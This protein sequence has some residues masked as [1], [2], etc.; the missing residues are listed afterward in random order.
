[1]YAVLL[2][3]APLSA[4]AQMQVSNTSP[5]QN[6]VASPGTSISVTF[7]QT[8][9][10]SANSSWMRVYSQFGGEVTGN[11]TT[12]GST[13]SFD[14]DSL[15]S[16]G[17]QVTVVLNGVTASGGDTL[18]GY[19][20]SFYIQSGT[21]TSSPAFFRDVAN[22]YVN[23]SANNAL[24][25]DMNGDH[26]PDLIGT[27]SIRR[28]IYLIQNRE[29]DDHTTHFISQES[30][31][32]NTLG[33]ATGDFD[34]DGDLDFVTASHGDNRLSLY[35][36]DG[37]GSFSYSILFANMASAA[38]ILRAVDFDNDNDTD[39]LGMQDRKLILLEND[40]T[41]NFTLSTLFDGSDLIDYSLGDLDGNGGVDVLASLYSLS[42]YFIALHNDGM[43][44]ISVDTIDVGAIAN[45]GALADI[46]KDGVPEIISY[47]SYGNL[48]GY[49]L[50]D[51]GY[52]EIPIADN[53][54]GSYKRM[55][56]GDLDGDG[57]VDLL[58]L[59][60]GRMVWFENDGTG[61]F[62]MAIIDQNL[63][64]S[65]QMGIVDW[66]GDGNVDLYTVDS[67]TGNYRWYRQT[68]PLQQNISLRY[69][70]SP[71]MNNETISLKAVAGDTIRINMAGGNTGESELVID[72]TVASSNLT[73]LQDLD[74]SYIHDIAPTDI[75]FELVV[76]AAGNQQE[77]Y[78]VYSNDPDDQVYTTYFS[79]EVFDPL[80]VTSSS[81][82]VMEANVALDAPISLGFS[83]VLPANWADYRLQV[84]GSQ[85]GLI[86][87]A[88]T[89]DN[90]STLSFVAD[91]NYHPAEKISVL[92]P[93]GITSPNGPVLVNSWH[94]TFYASNAPT[95]DSPVFFRDTL[96]A[97]I[98]SNSARVEVIDLDANG[99]PELLIGGLT[100]NRDVGRIVKSDSGYVS[101][102]IDNST[103]DTYSYDR[104]SG[105]G[106]FM[107]NEETALITGSRYLR[108][109]S[110][111][112]GENF[113]TEYLTYQSPHYIDGI[114]VGDIDNDGM[115][116]IISFSSGS[117]DNVFIYFSKSGFSF[118]S[119]NYSES[120][121]M[122]DLELF[123]YDLDGDL[124]IVTSNSSSIAYWTNQGNANFSIEYV[125]YSEFGT[126]YLEVADV[127]MD[128]YPDVVVSERYGDITWI[129]NDGGTF[130]TTEQTLATGANGVV[131][132]IADHDQDGDLD[133]FYFADNTIYLLEQEAI[134][135][136]S[137]R[138][139]Y[140][141]SGFVI[142][143]ALAD[144]DQ[145]GDLDIYFV[146]QKQLILLRNVVPDPGVLQV[147]NGLGTTLASESTLD[148][149]TLSPQQVRNFALYLDNTGEKDLTITSV[150]A[151]GALSITDTIGTIQNGFTQELGLSFTDSLTGL[152]SGTLSIHYAGGTDS[153]YTLTISAEIVNPLAAT[154]SGPVNNSSNVAAN[155]TASVVFS[156]VMPFGESH[157]D[158]V[159]LSG[160]ISG[161][162]PF[163]V[164]VQD[165]L[166]SFIP[167]QAFL[168]G[169][170]VRLL[171]PAGLRA[172]DSTALV[173]NQQFSYFIASAAPDTSDVTFI[174]YNRF[175][176]SYMTGL[177][178]VDANGDQKTDI[179]SNPSSLLRL[180]GQTEDYGFT[181]EDLNPAYRS[182]VIR[183]L[184]ADLDGDLDFLTLNTDL[185][186]HLADSGAYTTVVLVE[187]MYNNQ[188]DIIVAHL[189]DDLLPDIAAIDG[190]Q[191]F[192]LINN[193][194]GQFRKETL[195]DD[196]SALS[197]I[198]VADMNGDGYMDIAVGD[199]NTGNHY[200]CFNDGFG[201]FTRAQI[202]LGS[203][204]NPQQ[205]VLRDFDGDGKNDLLSLRLWSLQLWTQVDSVSFVSETILS[206]LSGTHTIDVG[207]IDGDG[208]QDFVCHSANVSD[209][210]WLENVDTTYTRHD[211]NLDLA[212]GFGQ[213]KNT[214]RLGDFDDDG[215][216]DLA[217]IGE[218][219][220]QDMLLV[221]GNYSPDPLGTVLTYDG[222]EL[223]SGDTVDL[224][225]FTQGDLST[226]PLLLKNTG[227][228][229]LSIDSLSAESPLTVADS[230][231]SLAGKETVSLGLTLPVDF[232]GAIES[233]VYLSTN[234]TTAGTYAIVFTGTVSSIAIPQVT[235]DSTVY[236]STSYVDYGTVNNGTIL[237]FTLAN[238][239]SDTLSIT[240]FTLESPL[241]LLDEAPASVAPGEEVSLQ[242][243]VSASYS[244]Y[245]FPSISFGHNGVDSLFL[246]E[247]FRVYVP[248]T[249]TVTVSFD[250][251]L[252]APGDTLQFPVTAQD[253]PVSK[254]MTLTNT[255]FGNLTVSDILYPYDMYVN[256]GSS[257]VLGE[258]ESTEIS[259]TY[260][261][262]DFGTNN[263]YI[264]I[265][266]N[267]SENPS[268][269]VN[270]VTQVDSVPEL[271]IRD[272]FD[273]VASG[274]SLVFGIIEPGD[275][276]GQV[277]TVRN[278]GSGALSL[279]SL[280]LPQG[281]SSSLTLPIELAPDEELDFSINFVPVTEG[282]FDGTAILYNNDSDEG[283]FEWQL[284]G[285][286]V[287]QPVM[288]LIAFGD[289][290]GSGQATPLVIAAPYTYP[291]VNIPLSNSGFGDLVI[292]NITV[293]GGWLF[294]GVL[295]IVVAPGE[296]TVLSIIAPYTGTT[297]RLKT[298]T[299]VLS[300]NQAGAESFELVA[301]AFYTQTEYTFIPSL[302][303]YE[304]IADGTVISSGS[305][306]DGTFDNGGSGFP[307]G[308]DFVIAGKNVNT[309]A[310][311]NNGWIKLDS[312]S[313]SISGE[314]DFP[315]DNS[316]DAYDYIVSAASDLIAESADSK[317]SYKT[318]GEPGSQTLVVQWEGYGFYSAVFGQENTVSFQIRLHEGSNEIEIHFDRIK[319]SN[320]LNELQA[321]WRGAG[322][323]E[324]FTRKV[325][326]GEHYW[327]SS[328]AG[329]YYDKMKAV[330]D[331][332]AV[333]NLSYVW[334]AP[335]LQISYMGEVLERG[336]TI[337][338]IQE[339]LTDSAS[340]ELVFTNLGGGILN[341]SSWSY[342]N[343]IYLR[344]PNRLVSAGESVTGSVAVDR[345]ADRIIDGH[346]TLYTNEPGRDSYTSHFS[347]DFDYRGIYYSIEGTR[348][349]RGDEVNM[350]VLQQGTTEKEV[351]LVNTS[352]D[353]A[354][355]AES[356]VN[357]SYDY[358]DRVIAPGDSILQL[359]GITHYGEGERSG[360]FASNFDS[361]FVNMPLNY[362]GTMEEGDFAE[363]ALSVGGNDIP[364]S[365]NTSVEVNLGTTF[366]GDT[367]YSTF[368]ISNELGTDT[369]FISNIE[370]PYRI[371][372][373]DTLPLYILPGEFFNT[374][375]YLVEQTVWNN[376][377]DY[378]RFDTNTDRGRIYLNF[379][380]AVSSDSK[381]TALTFSYKGNV[382][383]YNETVDLGTRYNSEHRN[384]TLV[385][386]NTSAEAVVV[387]SVSIDWPFYI[388]QSLPDTLEP[389]S[390][391]ELLL[392]RYGNEGTFSPGLTVETNDSVVYFFNF[393]LRQLP[394]PIYRIYSRLSG[395]TEYQSGAYFM[396]Y[397]DLSTE[398]TGGLTLT[399]TGNQR[400]EIDSI[401]VSD[402]I[403]LTGN[404]QVQMEVDAVEEYTYTFNPTAL[405]VFTETIT[406]YSNA[407]NSPEVYTL[408]YEVVESVSPVLDLYVNG[409]NV[410]AGELRNLGYV[411]INDTEQISVYF[412][413][414]GYDTLEIPVP[415]VA[416][417]GFYWED[418][419]AI[420]L[421]PQENLSRSLLFDATTIG[422]YT[423][424][425]DL[426]NNTAV[427]DF[428]FTVE[429]EVV[430]ST[431][432]ILRMA[433][434]GQEIFGGEIIELGELLKTE[435]TT[436][437]ILATN[438]GY[439][440]ISLNNFGTT[441]LFVYEADPTITLSPGDT[442]Y[443]TLVKP[444]G[445][446]ALGL[447]NDTF[448]FGVDGIQETITLTYELTEV[449][450][451]LS[452][453][454]LE[455]L[456][457]FPN[458]AQQTI[459]L[460]GDLLLEQPQ[461]FLQDASGRV[462][463]VEATRFAGA[464]Q[465][466]VDISRL[467]AGVYILRLRTEDTTVERRFLKQ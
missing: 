358:T 169:E 246:I 272:G 57:D 278:L 379:R 135:T 46:N 208:D 47:G 192:I 231:T 315:L 374:D 201:S 137:S 333:N 151:S 405:G 427:A 28:T 271:R 34:R 325:T 81:P 232:A 123:D 338:L 458:P 209:L 21:A 230:L 152:S 90:D 130:E 372:L 407:T 419:S 221:Y 465:L 453:E 238:L 182:S 320:G 72:S 393:R 19:Q 395:F 188:E 411:A 460:R 296:E 98:Y 446:F 129:R 410:E 300:T 97:S 391:H 401:V 303:A 142:N 297:E 332:R 99:S 118:D 363:I 442:V 150:S 14:P 109:Y 294:S 263:T 298:G 88:W 127:D 323:D 415:S 172:E 83:D 102:V 204:S 417:T 20:F 454:D 165:S 128:G 147:Q 425:V 155:T 145:D 253:L 56:A 170:R 223:N 274:D 195:H 100:N 77:S 436:L 158:G 198:D 167:S 224:G 112:G 217:V 62:T 199:Y 13:M 438:D 251:E 184:D 220:S 78:A 9:S 103:F 467:P 314:N 168:P 450:S 132:A 289:T 435:T 178:L 174:E 445:E 346:F 334:G 65:T 335:K 80:T 380:Y 308:F 45:Y 268:F 67:N 104:H 61:Y 211:I 266:S 126:K 394:D 191:Q 342:N 362:T 381:G 111:S 30:D 373:S 31:D 17:E 259:V 396:P 284:F 360:R 288:H 434:E 160:D 283:S 261:A 368:T 237:D 312:S 48:K 306:D 113:T 252:Y 50:T 76:G 96:I 402:G 301:E 277:Y 92:V 366:V 257:R 95:E 131:H 163:A 114:H 183:H 193:G 7:D 249:P 139:L 292:D 69:Q 439:T 462:L 71:L 400:I 304:P 433:Y 385:V 210:Y 4:F 339:D 351:Y 38:Y 456:T 264:S 125:S 185:T 449:V 387:N 241:V 10:A 378:M 1:M 423:A 321:G 291:P 6:N 388:G 348:Y 267:D 243:Q 428:S 355:I 412:R 307:V 290:I 451:G 35:T 398:V 356:Y 254:P 369:L 350:G 236:T 227:D 414:T 164:D 399:N 73:I 280:S 317:I 143:F 37:T 148:L 242:V 91:T 144:D 187:N 340:V 27:T 110:H 121:F 16:P 54:S 452:Q 133:L 59:S 275:S 194:N 2:L 250:G 336:Q 345:N 422:V 23:N 383:E 175:T 461:I 244:G 282:N 330:P 186:L 328:A 84:K 26:L 68:A 316:S 43:G 322:T 58:A 447:Y 216:L 218:I 149:G 215:V 146:D 171:L 408:R 295:P 416:G 260:L 39:I 349:Y 354:Y 409:L 229:V 327:E 44:N 430:E 214:V 265:E 262:Y 459:Y 343:D 117:S 196:Y 361:P 124:D 329:E 443:F 347:G 440:D 87:G 161:T 240:D 279:D 138:A 219:N 258:G 305:I 233:L 202:D 190:S 162:M 52:M 51:S 448:Q 429:L 431:A 255:G 207:D 206:D 370:M 93:A 248:Y 245:F 105:I 457:L 3:L 403:A 426:A 107:Q 197:A 464:E 75:E 367:I 331:F 134:D 55:Q 341:L 377:Y 226:L 313:V 200:I 344:I 319:S 276:V 293:P 463:Q 437:S 326:G 25:A 285:E 239:G 141:T 413:N 140:Q 286:A 352:T 49:E 256:F 247:S 181:E 173:S 382:L 337:N 86:S 89:L 269:R 404:S 40:G 106:D 33:A 156:A 420:V 166:V 177:D 157:Y 24:V 421:P 154:L 63:S 309:F 371:V 70:D 441:A 455:K 466:S 101:Y 222:L 85:S 310:V 376:F 122:Y 5:L 359:I 41:G 228:Y 15:L 66:D 36:N 64:F 60:S 318:I 53:E 180:Y 179:V 432:G 18:G 136:W 29:G 12:S 299:F 424:Q 273:D 406:I 159:Q 120:T 189:N 94:G 119:I 287:L 108:G 212:I 364:V 444:A 82:A 203:S 386:T 281:Y 365:P 418:S 375:F 32:I 302:K 234:D 116:D 176:S 205:I 270:I 11:F 389:N 384:D 235:I 8:L 115:E 324:V 392:R 153:V 390:T 213:R 42:N 397:T 225:T 79:I 353:T 357:S 22:L 74:A 311:D